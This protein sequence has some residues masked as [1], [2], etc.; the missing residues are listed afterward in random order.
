MTLGDLEFS[1]R[2]FLPK[3]DS[4]YGRIE[5]DWMEVAARRANA[6]LSERLSKA[7]VVRGR[8]QYEGL[9]KITVWSDEPP[10]YG[11]QYQARLVA[12]EEIGRGK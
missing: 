4:I 1:G 8:E 10:E 11:D 7:P 3:D 2:D 5:Y 9:S 6:L 12:I